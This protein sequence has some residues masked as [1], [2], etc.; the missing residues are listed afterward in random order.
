M[1]LDRH[2]RDRAADTLAAYLRGEADNFQL[3]EDTMDL[4]TKDRALVVI[5]LSLWPLY[6]DISPHTVR[7]SPH[8][9]RFMVRCIAFLRT[10]LQEPTRPR[11][12]TL[13]YAPFHSVEQWQVY[14]HLIAND[15]LPEHDPA[16]HEQSIPR[17][18]MNFVAQVVLIFGGMILLV[19]LITSA[20]HGCACP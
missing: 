9:W 8:G 16:L 2:N 15:D 14:Q 11:E 4:P 7:A 5:S 17:P 20:N 13:E 1:H 19:L 18:A 6:D 12:Q 3:I 10:D